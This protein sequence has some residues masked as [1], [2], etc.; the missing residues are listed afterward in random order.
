MKKEVL[1]IEDRLHRRM[2]ERLKLNDLPRWVHNIGLGGTL[3]VFLIFIIVFAIFKEVAVWEAWVPADEFVN[4][5]YNERIYP[6]SVFRTRMN[7][8][9]NL[10]YILFGFYA[11]ALAI[12]D[13]KEC[14]TIQ[15][16]Y[17]SHVPIQSL[18]FG[19]AAVYLG[20]G[21]SFFHASLTRYGQQCDVG[22]MYATMIC[23]GAIAIGSWMPRMEL[24]WYRRS[25]PTWPIISV[26]VVY[27]SIYFSYYKWDYS[28]TEVTKYINAVL[29]LFAGVSV[30]QPG[31]YLQTGW[32][33]A[34][35]ATIIL[36]SKIRDLD[37]AGSFSS[38]DSFFQ[39]HALWHL[40]S[41]LFYVFMFFYFRSEEREK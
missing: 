11:M 26:L 30:I 38:P 29:F 18:L 40:V 2:I 9:S 36:G 16:G 32:F 1:P 41:C 3:I 7:T 23:M 6:D 10:G 24:P 19:L 17:L 39:G 22:G 37:I 27:A 14:R 35:I 34:A 33:V 31:K 25:F 13:W 4:P 8:W 21:S 28:F 5:E 15:K 12:N 20:F